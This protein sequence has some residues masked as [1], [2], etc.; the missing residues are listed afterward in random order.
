MI[1]GIAFKIFTFSQVPKSKATFI[2]HNLCPHTRLAILS[3]CIIDKNFLPLTPN[4]FHLKHTPPLL[5]LKPVTFLIHLR[6][7]FHAKSQFSMP[8]HGDARSNDNLVALICDAVNDLLIDP[9]L[10]LITPGDCA[11]SSDF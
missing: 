11:S 10:V 3:F 8:N 4:H 5:P 2:P 7:V 6:L 1:K 9:G